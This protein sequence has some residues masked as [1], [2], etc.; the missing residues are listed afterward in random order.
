MKN[1]VIGGLLFASALTHAVLLY[2]GETGAKAP[3]AA[4]AER[5]REHP[6]RCHYSQRHCIVFWNQNGKEFMGGGIMDCADASAY[7]ERRNKDAAGSHWSREIWVNTLID[8]ETQ[9]MDPAKFHEG[10]PAQKAVPARGKEP[11][12]R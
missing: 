8:L 6:D 3:P 1:E 9:C 2:S 10:Q 5:E 7:V 12:R 11:Q 4:S